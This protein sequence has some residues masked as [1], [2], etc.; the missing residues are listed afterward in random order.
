MTEPNH[1]ADHAGGD[2]S[3]AELGFELPTAA[4][5]SRVRVLALVGVAIAGAFA[6]GYLRRGHGAAAATEDSGSSGATGGTGAH[7]VQVTKATVLSSDRALELPGVIRPLEETKVYPRVSGYVKK[8]NVDIGDKVEAGQELAEIDAPELEA[9]LAQARAQVGQAQAAVKQATAQRDYSKANAAR[10]VGLA[11]QKLVAQATVEQA[12]AQAATDD[13]NVT[14]QNANVVAA[15][16]NV[17]KLA[18]QIGYSHVI[19]PFKGTITARYVDRGAAVVGDTGTTPLFDLAGTDPV[20]VFVDMPQTV[21]P[22]VKAALPATIMTREYGD[23]VFKGEVTRAAGALDPAL[24]TMS[25][26]LRFPNSDGALI[27][28]MYVQASIS[29]PVPHKVLEIPAT[30]LYSDAQGLRVAV[31]TAEH[32]IHFAKITIERD[33]GGTLWIAT[34]LTGDEQIVKIAAPTLV[35]NDAV[36]IAK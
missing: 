13:A 30:A 15:E 11:D 10:Q 8:W 18:E 7:L 33:T 4:R 9:Q 2:H 1:D 5:S 35:E 19:A 34:G 31:V 23:R 26:E 29:L 17:H 36:D 28:G 14:A 20:R 3:E 21:A 12:V 16:A 6:F 27:P 25:T 24:H 32:K 22:N